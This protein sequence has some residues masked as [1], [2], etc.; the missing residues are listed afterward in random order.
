MSYVV[1]K[2]FPYTIKRT[3]KVQLENCTERDIPIGCVLSQTRT[4]EFEQQYWAV[5]G[6]STLG[7]IILQVE[8]GGAD[9]MLPGDTFSIVTYPQRK[10]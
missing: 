9:N 5:I 10:L 1:N 7:N 6:W 3:W 8:H 4:R 2:A